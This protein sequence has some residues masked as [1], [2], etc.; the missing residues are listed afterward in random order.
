[1][2][3]TLLLREKNFYSEKLSEKDEGFIGT[4]KESV[5]FFKGNK[6][7]LGFILF[8]A[9]FASLGSYLDE[10]DALIINDFKLNTIWVS[11]ILTVRFVFVALGDILAPIVQKKLRSVR[12][13]SIIYIVGCICLLVF[14]M[15]W[16]QAGILIFGLAAM[17]MAITEI[18][19]VDALQNEIKEE[20]RATLMSFYGVAQNIVMI[21]FSLTYAF[22]VKIITLNQVYLILSVYGIIGGACFYLIFKKMSR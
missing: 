19:F 4:L 14:S 18:L 22:L 9:F 6:A 2:I 20:G 13:I 1:V 16:H 11:V 17:I 8:L 3:F 7:A 12:Q 21:C 15:I 5:S 10:F